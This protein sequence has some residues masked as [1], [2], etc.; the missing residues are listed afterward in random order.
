MPRASSLPRA[1]GVGIAM[2]LAALCTAPSSVTAQTSDAPLSLA[3]AIQH[4]QQRSRRIAAQVANAAAARESAVAAAQRPDPVLRIGVNNLPIEGAGRFEVGREPMTTR[5]LGVVQTLTRPD[6]L[7]ARRSRFEREA[8][9]AL[10]QRDLVAAETA[11]STAAAWLERHFQER[12]LALL[13]AQRAEAALQADGA[14]ATYR[15]GRGR[16]ADLWAARLALTQVDDRLRGAEAAVQEARVALHRWVGDAAERPLA[17]P[18]A[19]QRLPHDDAR[20]FAI[21]Q[22]LPEIAAARRREA[23]LD[24]EAEVARRE[25][26]A[27]WS[28]ELGYALRGSAFSNVATVALSI[29]LRWDLEQRQDRELAAR[30]AR[31]A[32][33]RAEREELQRARGAELLRQWHAWQAAR[34]RIELADRQLLPLAAERSRAALAAYAGGSGALEAVLTARRQE[35]DLRIDRERLA[36]D[37]ARQWA[38]LE[39][40]LPEPAAPQPSRPTEAQP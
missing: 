6:K 4:A 31:A 22:S 36:L 34:D 12:V 35:V 15:A 8:D 10:A 3:E 40:A 28:L 26:D 21:V 23:V 9:A 5:S 17:A 38:Q 32:A 30:L 33:A 19:L 37:A 2:V 13:R 16:Q 20:L 24:A 7:A 27:D 29:P 1:R 14:E 11:R 18:P 25:R 39:H